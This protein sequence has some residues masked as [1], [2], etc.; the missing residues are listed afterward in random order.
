[1]S[2]NN[3]L[4]A[5]ACM[6]LLFA[7]MPV[8]GENTGSNA[9]NSSLKSSRQI[10]NEAPFGTLFTTPQQREA[11]DKARRSG[12]TIRP[13]VSGVDENS[14]TSP[15]ANTP[16]PIKLMGVLLR[17]DGKNKVWLS[18]GSNTFENTVNNRAIVGNISQSANVKVPL[19]DGNNAAILKPGQVWSPS[20]GRAEEAYQ[21]PVPKPVVTEPVAKPLAGQSPSAASSSSA[22]S[23]SVSSLEVHSSVPSSTK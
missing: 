23:S 1:M 9:A 8:R 19:R 21:V 18:G 17:A 15:I 12:G 16:Q 6:V 10:V 7:V 3:I 5:L 14:T 11:L 4:S 22:Q 13:Q 2:H 20:K